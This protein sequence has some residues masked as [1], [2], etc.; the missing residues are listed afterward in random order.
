[1]FLKQLLLGLGLFAGLASA[2]DYP[3]TLLTIN[4]AE[5]EKR[6]GISSD[7][8]HVCFT[9]VGGNLNDVH[10]EITNGQFGAPVTDLLVKDGQMHGKHLL[11]KRDSLFNLLIFVP[12]VID[13]TLN[14]PNERF[15]IIWRGYGNA[16]LSYEPKDTSRA[17]SQI[18]ITVLDGNNRLWLND[19]LVNGENID[20]DTKG[21]GHAF[22]DFCSKWIR[23]HVGNDG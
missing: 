19:G 13:F 20:I 6:C 12:S 5:Y 10:V 3:A 9:F 15:S 11:S 2:D 14:D 4:N 18:G 16:I 7:P 23:I 8:N 22:G 17:C 1:M 21:S